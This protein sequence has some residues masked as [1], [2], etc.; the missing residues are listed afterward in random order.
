MSSAESIYYDRM[1][2]ELS[3][4]TPWMVLS[5]IGES[6]KLDFFFVFADDTPDV[7]GYPEYD[8]AEEQLMGSQSTLLPHLID[9]TRPPT[10]LWSERWIRFVC[11][12]VNLYISISTYT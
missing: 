2:Y 11:V 9:Q 8:L 3:P 6:T 7:V 4:A 5:A 12:C 1:L 10:S